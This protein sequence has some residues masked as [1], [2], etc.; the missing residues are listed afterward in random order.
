MRR[1]SCS[2]IGARMQ[3]AWTLSQSEGTEGGAKVTRRRRFT[4]IWHLLHTCVV[5]HHGRREGPSR[6]ERSAVR[7]SV[8]LLFARYAYGAAGVACTLRARFDG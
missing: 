4:G 6:E 7:E 5:C 3:H 8:R 2:P 1:R